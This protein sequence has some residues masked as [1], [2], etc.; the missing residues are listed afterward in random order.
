MC[1]QIGKVNRCFSCR[2]PLA[3]TVKLLIGAD[4]LCAE[5]VTCIARSIGDLVGS[6]RSSVVSSASSLWK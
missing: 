2:R 5:H 6:L 3:L 1:P 4:N